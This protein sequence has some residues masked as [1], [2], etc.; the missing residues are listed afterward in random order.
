MYNTY[1]SGIPDANHSEM[2]KLH[3]S[4]SAYKTVISALLKYSRDSQAVIAHRQKEALESLTYKRRSEAAELMMRFCFSIP[5]NG[6]ASPRQSDSLMGHGSANE[7][8]MPP[9][10]VSLS[11]TGREKEIEALHNAFH[12][13]HAE[14]FEWQRRFVLCGLG[15]SGKTQIAAKYAQD[16]R[17]R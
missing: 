14:S 7:Y 11:F 16:N 15:G 13:G 6:P 1:R 8:F 3:R 5:N 2:V 12:I 4:H 10:P 9:C 17:H